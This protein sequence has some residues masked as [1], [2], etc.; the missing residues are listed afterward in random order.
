MLE[1]YRHD[2]T[3]NFIFASSNSV[4]EGNKKLPFCESLSVNHPLSLY[5]STKK[6]NELMAHS[7]SHLYVIPCIHLRFFTVY[8]PW[9]PRDM[10]PMIFVKS[11]LNG[12][13][14]NFLIT[15]K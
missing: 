7:Y 5:A 3:D 8:G 13:A 15:E 10:A 9:G 6:A 4:Y 1:Q 14:I 11:I 2:S 12:T